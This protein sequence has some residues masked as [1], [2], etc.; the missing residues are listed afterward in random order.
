[1]EK[2]TKKLQLLIA[3]SIIFVTVLNSV[4]VY[5]GYNIYKNY[6]YDDQVVST[7][8]PEP[9]VGESTAHLAA[10]Q[11]H[12]A[13]RVCSNYPCYPKFYYGYRATNVG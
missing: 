6:T 3:G 7:Q 4:L 13:T 10:E 1:M 11:Y 2:I 9:K 5:A 12:A 8:L